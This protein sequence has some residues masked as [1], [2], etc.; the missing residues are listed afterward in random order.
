[1]GPYINTFRSAWAV[2]M[3]KSWGWYSFHL[4]VMTTQ[5]IHVPNT[6]NT[7]HDFGS[8]W[9][10]G[11]PGRFQKNALLDLDIMTRRAKQQTGR[12]LEIVGCNLA[13]LADGSELRLLH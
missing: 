12:T 10:L 1:M 8:G 13:M 6:W 5:R 3:P 2:R 4:P 9:L 7:S 11:R